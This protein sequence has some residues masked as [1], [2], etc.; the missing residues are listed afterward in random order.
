MGNHDGTDMSAEA[1]PT[2]PTGDTSSPVLEPA[3]P[4]TAPNP[5]AVYLASRTAASRRTMVTALK[6]VAVL[7]QEEGH[8]TAP[9]RDEPYLD[10]SWA[11]LRRPQTLQLRER[12]RQRYAP[13]TAN[14]LLVALR[15]VLRVAQQLGQISPQDA[16]QALD[17]PPIPEHAV[18]R[19][20]ILSVTELAALRQV[21]AVDRTPAGSRDGA[22]LI[23]LAELG[24]RRAEVTALDL[25]DVDTSAVQLV[26]RG[27]RGG[28]TRRADLTAES[29]SILQQWIVVR[30]S[31]PGPLFYGLVKGG[32]LVTRRLAPQAVA[33]VCTARASEAGIAPFTPD[34]L[35]RT[36][37]STVS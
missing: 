7:L 13:A 15:G 31:V 33:V 14:K 5:A 21:C 9:T 28:V 29:V 1:G 3:E 19:R 30:G 20:R 26:I 24:L 37:L 18:R 12:L 4:H 16:A 10:I 6:A 36:F 35:R 8:A 17:I 22:L 11:S 27:G 25:E 32:G 34:D 2:I 23:L